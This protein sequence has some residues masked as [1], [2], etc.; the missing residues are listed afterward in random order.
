MRYSKVYI[1]AIF[2]FDNKEEFI[3]ERFELIKQFS[4]HKIINLSDG[5]KTELNANIRAITDLKQAL[6]LTTG[7]FLF[8]KNYML[9]LFVK[10]QLLDVELLEARLS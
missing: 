7:L 6:L 9:E 10:N 4:A 5:I 8:E 3:N 1:K 2:D